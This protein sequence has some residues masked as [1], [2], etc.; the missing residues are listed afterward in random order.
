MKT[1]LL[2]TSDTPRAA[3]TKPIPIIIGLFLASAGGCWGTIYSPFDNA[4]INTYATGNSACRAEDGRL[5]YSDDQETVV[6]W[7]GTHEI[8]GTLV[9]D[10]AYPFSDGPGPDFAILTG[11]ESWGIYA[12]PVRFDFYLNGSLQGSLDANLLPNCLNEFEM[13]NQVVL[14]DSLC[15]VNIAP[16]V[17]IN[18]DADLEILDAGVR[19][20]VPEPRPQLLF[21]L[22]GLAAWCFTRNAAIVSCSKIY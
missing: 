17:G 9:M 22:G 2:T 21:C 4:P 18:N 20:V 19:Y 8:P 6:Y 12:G 14:A 11:A 13:P 10:F 3:S 16:D 5:W 15:L 1:T 7:L